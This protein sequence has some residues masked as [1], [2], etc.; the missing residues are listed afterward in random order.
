MQ[1]YVKATVIIEY[2]E[3]REYSDPFDG[4]FSKNIATIKLSGF[5][6]TDTCCFLGQ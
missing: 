1:G 4:E 5:P 3:F 2:N 6:A